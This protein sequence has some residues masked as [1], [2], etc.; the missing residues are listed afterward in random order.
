MP[1][2]PV[3]RG[4]FPPA[5]QAEVISL[6]SE[7][8]AEHNCPATR[9]SLDDL[10][11]ELIQ[12]HAAEAMHRSTVWRILEAADLKPHRSVYWLNSHDP[13]FHT[14]ATEICQFYVRASGN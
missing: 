7:R 10:V 1:R 6:A 4:L 11:H 2:G 14:K 3:N 9:W 8:T 12:R 13:D 5:D